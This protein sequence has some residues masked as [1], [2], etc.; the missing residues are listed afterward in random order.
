MEIT[1]L[2][3]GIGFHF[4]MDSELEITEELIPFVC[5]DKK[6]ADID[7]RVSRDWNKVVL[8]ETEMQGED[9]ILE[10]YLQKNVRFC[11]AKGGPKGIVACSCYTADFGQICCTLNDEPFLYPT[12]KLGS[13]LRMLPVREIFLH[14]HT[15]FFHASQIS[16]NGKGIMFSAPAGTGKST[17]AKLWR[18]YCDAEIVCN[19]RTLLH[20]N[21]GIWHTYGYPLDGSEPVR[22]NQVNVLGCIVL[23]EQGTENKVQRVRPGK[24]ISRM[25]EQII[26]DCWNC[27]ERT[28]AVE[29]IMDLLNDIPVY[30][31]TCTPDERAVKVLKAKLIEDGVIFDGKVI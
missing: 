23:L 29:L 14:F 5:P 19:D 13:V 11:L 7:I 16:Y 2:L 22:S 17:Q 18:H 20:K 4:I 21:N 6:K 12:K 1:L 27:K 24:A 26:I 25:M 3:G 10:Y 8:P 9:A 30:L 31:L 15:L 28:L